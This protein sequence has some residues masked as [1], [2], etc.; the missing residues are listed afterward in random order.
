MRHYW[1]MAF[2]S[3]F[4]AKNWWR[5]LRGDAGLKTLI[6][7]AGDV[8]PKTLAASS[9][10]DL[11]VGDVA[12]HVASLAERHVRLLHV[13][14]EGDEGLDYFHVITGGELRQWREAGFLQAEVI[15][16]A[17]HTFTLLWSQEWLLQVIRGWM[18][19]I[20]PH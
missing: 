14:S 6:R 8:M 16:G 3:S 13:Y 20:V 17:D 7:A 4:R 5:V 1:R 9:H 11:P 2:S 19:H 10:Q 18:Q 12:A 15:R